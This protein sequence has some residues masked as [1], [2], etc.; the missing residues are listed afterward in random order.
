MPQSRARRRPSHPRSPAKNTV[1]TRMK[2]DCRPGARERQDFDTLKTLNIQALPTLDYDTTAGWRSRHRMRRRRRRRSADPASKKSAE[3]T[4]LRGDHHASA[5]L[6][7]PFSVQDL[8][9]RKR[10]E[11][12]RKPD[13]PRLP[14]SGAA[15]PVGHGVI[16]RTLRRECWLSGQCLEDGGVFSEQYPRRSAFRSR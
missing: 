12:G 8:C 15:E 6:A 14:Q 7:G 4:R 10:V 1:S 11:F 2:R 5:H 9:G 13:Y 16:G 3:P